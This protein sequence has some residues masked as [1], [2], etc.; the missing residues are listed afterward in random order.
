MISCRLAVQCSLVL[1]LPSGGR[2]ALD[3][4]AAH[5]APE[6]PQWRGP[7][8]DGVSTEKGLLQK[9]APAGPPLAWKASGLGK[10]LAS[11]AISAGRIYTMG[12]RKGAQVLLALDL[13]DGR[14]VW[15][16]VV[17]EKGGED[18]HS[19]PTTD[20]ERVYAIGPQGDLVCV[21]ADTG[22][23]LWR[24]S[25]TS[26]F[27]GSAPGWNY[28]ESPLVD[29]DR[30]LCTPGG[31]GATL[32]A[33]DRKT[34]EVAWKCAVPGGAGSGFGY[35]SIVVSE[36]GGVRQ[37]VQM[38]GQGTGCVGVAAKDGAFLWK[39]PRVGNGTATIPTPI[40]DG[41]HVFCS[42]GYNTGTAL[43][44]LTRDGDKVKAEE[45]YFIK[46]SRLQNHHGGL[47]R[48][49]EFIYGGHGHNQGHPICVEMKTGRI[50]WGGDVPGP[51]KKSAAVV[52]A[53]GQL[54]FRYEDGVMALI[55]ASKDGLRINGAFQIPQVAGPSWSHPVVAGG[56]LYLR[57]QDNL[58]VYD[59]TSK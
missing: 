9:W 3:A 51:G 18:P 25:F 41:D 5:G 1:L 53:D 36:G 32:V 17:R 6:W 29:G 14:E 19:T 28:C 48:V 15:A 7:N 44:K 23:E 38:M 34:G 31:N 37:Y 47:V 20:G 27:G 56:L 58:F 50:A 42:S 22:K 33:L 24:K 40:V 45:V 39:Y 52:Y 12:K 21:T 54:Y 10:G 55:S 11:V 30:V 4:F 2:D 49:G 8:R 43:L 26:D 16:A 57:E 46:G 35:S 13:R 59:V